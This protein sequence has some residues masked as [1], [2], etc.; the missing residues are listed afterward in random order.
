MTSD[1]EWT[2]CSPSRQ[3]ARAERS[4]VR[5]HSRGKKIESSELDFEN[6]TDRE[7][8]EVGPCQMAIMAK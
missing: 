4:K 6:Y 3:V 2:H 7:N 5:L 1:V 8:D